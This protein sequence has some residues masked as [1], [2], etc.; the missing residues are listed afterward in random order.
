MG[1][2]P[3]DEMKRDPNWRKMLQEQRV[4][5]QVRLQS[6]QIERV[7]SRHRVSGQVSGGE[8]TPRQIHFDLHAS[9]ESGLD[10]LRGLKQ[11]LL[12][13]LGVSDVALSQRGD[14]F[15]L[16]VARPEAP[17]VAL[18][19][20]LPLLPSLA[21]A[22]VTLG[23]GENGRPLLVELSD[24]DVAHVMISGS[25]SA[26]KTTLLRTIAV[27]LALT[28]R[29][30]QL[31]L[32]AINGAA[33]SVMEGHAILEPLTYLPHLLEPVVSHPVDAVALLNFLVEEVDY[34][35]EQEV[36]TPTIVVL[37]DGLVSLFDAAGSDAVNAVLQLLQKG[38][39]AGVHLVMATADPASAALNA[40]VHASIPVRIVG[41][42]DDETAGAAA[43]GMPEVHP[44]YLLGEGDFFAIV[45]D[46]AT[47]FQ[48]AYIGDYD[49]HLVLDT[50][51]RNR[52]QSLLAHP[53]NIRPT[54]DAE[55][56][57]PDE[58]EVIYRFGGTEQ[59][60]MVKE[61]A[62]VDDHAAAPAD[63]AAEDDEGDIPFEVGET[64]YDVDEDS[65]LTYEE[66]WE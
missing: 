51:H 17:P 42:I 38:A 25:S 46:A 4:P 11:E 60:T 23:L 22:T 9:L 20:L 1:V 12:S 66:V 50:L 57:E 29:Q 34:R 28:N 10:L 58:A 39:E 27:S 31:Q 44:E 7:M 8:V 49:L 19:D 24:K 61:S 16:H 15:R 41:Q 56:E 3:E 59:V 48:A 65:D 14:Q 21:P 52:P 5:H 63:D 40:F 53:V 18:L 6:E 35:L 26:G 45:D 13:V 30:S 32:V 37:I 47:Y 62:A 54:L 55:P 43:A 64:F 2:C 36:Q 33:G